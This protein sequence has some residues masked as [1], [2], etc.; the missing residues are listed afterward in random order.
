MPSRTATILVTDL[1]GSTQLRVRVGEDAADE[2]RRVHDRLLTEAVDKGGG[3]VVKG[4][5]DGV[6]AS[7]PSAAD[8][9][10]AAVEIQQAVDSYCRR[11]SEVHEVRIGISGGDISVEDDDIFGI[12]VVEAARLCS[13]ASGRQILVADLVKAMARGRG[14]HVFV[15]VGSLDLKGLDQPLDAHE[16]RWE[17]L[18]SI[19]PLPLPGRLSGDHLFGFV[20][21]HRQR[22]LLEA[23]WEECGA[24]HRRVVLLAGEAGIGKTRLANEIARS[25][26]N[27]GAVVLY[28]GCEEDLAA[29]YRPWIEAFSHLFEHA[30]VELLAGIDRRRLADVA[31]V[32]PQIHERVTDL[33]AVSVSDPET[34]R[35]L[36]YS[37]V[38]ALIASLTK[39]AP[40]L[41]MLDDLHWADKPSLVLLEHVVRNSEHDRLLVVGTY[42]DTDLG[43]KSQFGEALALLCRLTGVENVDLLGLDDDEIV[44]L[45]ELAV[46]H[47][48][49]DDGVAMARALYRETSG[50]PFFASEL[51]RHLTEV[52]AVS[53]EPNG[54]WSARFDVGQLVL[55]TSIRALIAQRL[56]RLGPS[57]Q[58]ALSHAC[59]VGHEFD[60]D[61]L[62]AVVGLDDDEL[63]DILERA[64]GAGIVES[65][66]AARFRFAHALVQHNLYAELSATRRARVHLT[67]AESLE[68]LELADNRAAEAA[69]HWAASGTEHGLSRAIHYSC[70]AGA[71]AG[72]ALAPQEAARH[73]ANAIE[74]LGRT[75]SSRSA[76]GNEEQHC[77]LLLLLAQAQCEA[78]DPR[79]RRTVVD[80]A[81][82]AE[83]RGDADRLVRA[84]LTDYQRGYMSV[85]DPDRVRI[86]ESAL[87]V[88]GE[89]DSPARVKL[90]SCLSLEL[91]FSDVDRSGALNEEARA[92]ARR[93]DDAPTRVN[94]WFHGGGGHFPTPEGI[95]ERRAAVIEAMA[96]VHE[97]GD[98]VLVFGA[99]F[100]GFQSATWLA[101]LDEIDR[102][103]AQMVAL[104]QEVERPDFRWIATYCQADRALL[105][106]DDV[107]SELLVADAYAIGR[108]TDQPGAFTLFAAGMEGVRWHQGRQAEMRDLLAEAAVKDPNLSIL[109][110]GSPGAS[111]PFVM[112]DAASDDDDLARMVRQLPRD[113]VWLISMTVLAEM[114]ARRGMRLACAAAY[115]EL[116]PFDGLFAGSTGVLRG[117]VAHYLG[118]LASAAGSY[119]AGERHFGD[120]ASTHE[121]MRAPF[122]VA[123][124]E[125]EWGRML[126]E[127][128]TSASNEAAQ[129]HLER[130][131]EIA[132]LHH[133]SQV[134]RRADRLLESIRSR[135]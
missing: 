129:Q 117:A 2:F 56:A 17:P 70:E 119:D 75:R 40:V 48:V 112:P 104:A 64:E 69:R 25:A 81:E 111:G 54:A 16:L 5:G 114:A 90:L 135:A 102:N 126:L 74:F 133:C 98:P 85:D 14:N 8:A 13:I 128:R 80:A 42:R 123:R 96:L 63:L 47:D 72:A 89:G 100:G 118:L 86:L 67:V 34:E 131:N 21:R 9:M 125:L 91:S 107:R 41:I 10:G 87:A 32:L 29:P 99:A 45:L 110:V 7:F 94:V 132:A 49:G 58:A 84:A 59:V 6:L 30:P 12:P 31:R 82:I 121:R 28:G 22:S 62:S 115:E 73:Y 38:L 52:G 27:E 108:E 26:H 36:F 11:H 44:G 18:E 109:G 127:G 19:S 116:L 122:H 55:P 65:L 66:S 130:A 60:F 120:A 37:G 20:G 33:P 105:A 35:Y 78:G 57:A 95:A 97:L 68:R 4:L 77:E 101:E 3:A 39:Q 106:G 93:I 92:I 46:G 76:P 88:V 50:N 23:G 61:V 15:S 1:V 134:E 24:G 113:Q 51:L 83:R 53:S 124:T 43:G 79:F 71:N 103:L